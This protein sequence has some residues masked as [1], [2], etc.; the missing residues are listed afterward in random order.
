MDPKNVRLDIYYKINS[1]SWTE[2]N[3]N[4]YATDVPALGIAPSGHTTQY[5][6]TQRVAAYKAQ[7]SGVSA[8]D[9]LS[10]KILFDAGGM[11]GNN[12]HWNR[13]TSTS[14]EGCSTIMA[15]EE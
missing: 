3:N 1:G 9:T 10:F 11:A 6:V 4:A 7:I 13:S 12:F 5:D 14:A 2:W 8:G 15:L